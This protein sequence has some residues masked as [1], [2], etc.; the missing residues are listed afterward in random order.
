M[1]VAFR[2]DGE[3]PTTRIAI[4]TPCHRFRQSGVNP[5]AVGVASRSGASFYQFGG[6]DDAPTL[7]R[8]RR[9]EPK[10]I[11]FRPTSFHM[12]SVQVDGSVQ[13]SPAQAMC[14]QSF[15]MECRAH[16]SQAGEQEFT[17]TIDEG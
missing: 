9:T 15:S 14:E 7:P 5:L 3:S 1:R 16:I 6:A 2:R 11:C 17:S 4:I 8:L 12:K 13:K 10:Y